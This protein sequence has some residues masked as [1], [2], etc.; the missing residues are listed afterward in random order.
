MSELSPKKQEI[1]DR[2]LR[3]LRLSRKQVLAGGYHGLGLETLAEELN[4]SR[5]TIYNHFQCK[6]EIIL[7]LLMETMDQRRSFLQRAASYRGVP[8][9]RMEAIVTAAELFARLRPDHF[10]IDHIVRSNSIR[11]KTTPARQSQVRSC[12]MQCQGILAGVVRDGMAQGELSLPD[13]ITPE[14]VVFGIWSLAEGAFAEITTSEVP[15]ELGIRQPFQAVRSSI[16]HLLDGYGWV[17]DSVT[18]D[19]SST[20]QMVLKDVFAEEYRQLKQRW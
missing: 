10:L 20:V 9:V 2:E 14:D 17:P 16:R 4:V 11:E 3:I 15:T 5:G 13:G 19:Y 6:E 12:R 18:H 1:R 7:A 8:R